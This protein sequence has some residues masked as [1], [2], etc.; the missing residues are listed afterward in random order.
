MLTTGMDKNIQLQ[1]LTKDN[2]RQGIINLMIIV[3][4]PTHKMWAS[5]MDNNR[6]PSYV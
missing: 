6:T 1:Y 5:I 4:V 2:T 3:K